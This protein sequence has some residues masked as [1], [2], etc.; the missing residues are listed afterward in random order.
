MRPAAWSAGIVLVLI[1]LDVLLP[2]LGGELQGEIA[3]LEGGAVALVETPALLDMA[4]QTGAAVIVLAAGAASRFGSPKQRLL[5]PHVL[6]RVRALEPSAHTG[7]SVGGTM[8]RRSQRWRD[9]RAA[10]VADLRR[11]VAVPVIAARFH[12]GLADVLV[13]AAVDGAATAGRDT[14]A[15]SGGVF[16]NVRLLDGISRRLTAAGLR[17]L[18]HSRVPCND[19]GISLGQV[20]VAAATCAP[21]VAAKPLSRHEIA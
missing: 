7:M 5:L 19:G 12:E 16:Q 14:V 15:L 10:V 18:V 13:R 11:G 3:L 4:M 21:E 20:A 6:D 9:W 2:R 1:A 8:A 17:V